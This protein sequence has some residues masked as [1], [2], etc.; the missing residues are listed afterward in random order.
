MRKEILI[1]LRW[2]GLQEFAVELEEMPKVVLLFK[3]IAD[4]QALKVIVS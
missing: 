3:R 4:G 1:S 2:E